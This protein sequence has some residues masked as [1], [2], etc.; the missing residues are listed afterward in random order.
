MQKG[1]KY[2]KRLPVLDRFWTKVNK[3]DSCWLWTGGMDGSGYGRFFN[4]KQVT[5]HRF[6]YELH[7]G[8]IPP[9]ICVLHHCDTPLCV[10]PSHLFLGTKKDN[11][12]DRENK[13][14]GGQ[15]IRRGERVGQS[16]LT[17]QQVLEIRKIGRSIS[18]EVI[19]ALYGV[20][21]T[22]VSNILTRFTWKHV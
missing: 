11:A 4:G 1:V 8:E 9:G 17:E 21:Q 10:N 22:A 3:T 20:K 18:Q 6:S 14:R 19:A 15:W 2:P 13:G 12:V 7:K 5:T 16:K